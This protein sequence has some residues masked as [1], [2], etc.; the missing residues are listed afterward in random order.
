MKYIRYTPR[1]ANQ[2][3]TLIRR[4]KLDKV[5]GVLSF[6]NKSMAIT[7]ILNKMLKN[8]LANIGYLHNSC[9]ASNFILKEAWVGQGPTLKR[10]VAGPR[11]R[12][13]PIKKRTVHITLVIEKI[14]DK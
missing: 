1:K 9:D 4:K 10:F 11:G 5:F 8:A 12:A 3:L 14:I 7:T 6:I 13:M 2:I